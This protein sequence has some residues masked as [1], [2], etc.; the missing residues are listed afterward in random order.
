MDE[1][2][3][4]KNEKENP[5]KKKIE[6]SWRCTSFTILLSIQKRGMAEFYR[7]FFFY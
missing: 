3:N 6:V 2:Y 4:Y 7:H 1:S 5:K